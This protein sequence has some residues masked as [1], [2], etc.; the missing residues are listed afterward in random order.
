MALN[1]SM[2]LTGAGAG[3]AGEI[4]PD[5]KKLR[6]LSVSPSDAHGGCSM[7]VK[8]LSGMFKAPS[9]ELQE[10]LLGYSLNKGEPF[11]ANEPAKYSSSKGLPKGHIKIENFLSV[12]VV[13]G[14]KVLGQI[15]LAN[16]KGGFKE[17]HLQAVTQLGNI[18]G[19]A[20]L[21]RRSKEETQAMEGRL[22]QAHKMEAIGALAGGI[23]HDFNNI[24]AAIM[25]YSEILLGTAGGNE[26]VSGHVKEL[27]VA[28]RRAKDLVNQ[29]LTFARKA[30]T[31]KR[32]I[33][34]SLIV[35][36]VAKMLRASVPSTIKIVQDVRSAGK[37]MIDP[38]QLNQIVLNLCTNAS[39][40]M[41]NGGTLDISLEDCEIA[42]EVEVRR[43]FLPEKGPYMKLTIKDD[44]VG[45]SEEVMGR[46]FEP[47]YTTKGEGKG[48]GMGLSMVHGIVDDCGG[49][50]SVESQLGTGTTFEVYFPLVRAEAEAKTEEEDN[51][52]PTGE[53]NILF[54]DDEPAM[55]DV[56]ETL[57][58]RMGYKVVG[59]SDSVEALETFKA[60]PDAFD[61]IITDMTMPGM[62]GDV[63]TKYALLTRPDL[64]IIICTGF[65]ERI[66]EEL[67]LSL[68]AKALLMKPVESAALA[69]A[70]RKHIKPGD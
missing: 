48:T 24:L 69:S 27:L 25:G 29:I 45:M 6:I 21:R 68:G 62:T 2:K 7:R 59:I 65:S 57:L 1:W 14:E 43:L 54:V 66:N 58:K 56:G 18:F 3:Y 26:K 12:P 34:V 17:R 30:D 41:P 63:L 10:G 52:A 9:Y 37:T 32:P 50:I 13:V 20:L 51:I 8:D 36:E 60:S 67:A 23:A 40:A 5:E 61:M 64:P 11:I 33:Q 42:S 15:V 46:I 38:A 55:V 16:A 28:A 47:F 22:V 53:G 49:S 19:T 44:G 39:H 31:E 70:V 4:P 35:K